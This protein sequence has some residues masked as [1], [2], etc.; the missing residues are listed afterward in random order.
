MLNRVALRYLIFTLIG[1]VFSA[2][3]ALA[4]VEGQT[5]KEDLAPVQISADQLAALH[6][7]ANSKFMHLSSQELA[8]ADGSCDGCI[9]VQ[10][11][12]VLKIK[13]F[14]GWGEKDFP[15]ADADEA[16]RCKRDRLNGNGERVYVY[17]TEFQTC[18]SVNDSFKAQCDAL[19]NHPNIQAYL[20]NLVK[21][22]P[23]LKGKVK[24]ECLTEVSPC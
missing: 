1:L 2:S 4:Q 13:G 23:Q 14:L 10:L 22:N 20:A 12:V 6:Q 11:A 18:G 5:S 8:A 9:N 3:L 19:I 24:F 17:W 15:H 16:K 7:F 21:A